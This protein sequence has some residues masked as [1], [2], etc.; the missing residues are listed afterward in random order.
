[1]AVFE[2]LAKAA[3]RAQLARLTARK[4][5]EPR[6]LTQSGV[7]GGAVVEVVE[8]RD[9]GRGPAPQQRLAQRGGCGP[10]QAPRKRTRGRLG[11]VQQAENR[12][13]KRRVGL[14]DE[15]GQG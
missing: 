7:R 8:R 14:V 11:G 13:G 3:A 4:R 6:Q 15:R 12:G 10:C 1:I 5:V 2:Q 9:L